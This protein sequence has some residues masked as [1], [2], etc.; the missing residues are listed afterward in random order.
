MCPIKLK[1]SDVSKTLAQIS[2]LQEQLH[3]IGVIQKYRLFQF[4]GTDYIVSP[5]KLPRVSKVK[6][7]NLKRT[8]IQQN[9][10]HLNVPSISNVR[11]RGNF[12]G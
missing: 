11:L 6:V 5:I 4:F 10:A 9:I 8:D 12:M 3:V 2:H 7:Q 1:N